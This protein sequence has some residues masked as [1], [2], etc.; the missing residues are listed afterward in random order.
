MHNKFIV[1]DDKTLITGSMNFSSTGFSGFNTNALLVVK[2]EDIAKIYNQEFEQMLSGKFSEN[3]SKITHKIVNLNGSYVTPYFSP[4]D[5]AIL[6]SIIP[7][8]NNSKSYIYMPAFVITHSK[9]ANAL[10][11]AKQRG[12]DVKIILDATGVYSTG[13]KIKLL[14]DSKIPLKVE[15]YAGKIHS[16]SM[17]V[18]DKYVV[19]GSMNFSNSGEN[20]NDENVL[21]IQDK[22]LTVF[23]KNFFLYLWNKIPNKYLTQNPKP[24]SK[25]SIGSC[26]DGIDND[27]DGKIDINDE[28]CK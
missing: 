8:V 26:Q 28:A 16:K 17:I 6:N 14:R 25:E 15:N 4:K 13:S 27:Y 3:K 20:K 12:V 19:I 11:A 1:I 21:V 9:L 10:I 7:I 23:Y 24:E 2:S 18:D 22:K 5:K